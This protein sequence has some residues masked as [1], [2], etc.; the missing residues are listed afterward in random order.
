[1]THPVRRRTP[2]SLAAALVLAAAPG[3]ACAVEPL[4]TFSVSVGSYIT[5]FD[6]RLRADGEALGGTS[7]DLS[8]DLGV[9]S[10]VALGFARVTW[11]PFERHEIGLSYFGN[12][13]DAERK[14]E[15]EIVFEDSVYLASATVRGRYDLDS[16][17]GYYTWWGF[18]S[19]NWALGPR[20]GVT[21]YRLALGLE[22]KADV[23]GDP[24]VDGTLE[25]SVNADLPAPTLGAAWRWTPAENWRIVADAGWFSTEINDIDGNVTY[26]RGGVEWYPWPRVGVMLDYTFSDIDARTARDAF[27]GHLELRN[28]GLRMG[29]VY[30]F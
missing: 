9:D 19:E 26:A 22:L 30:R 14:L 11:R 25:D 17:E 20:L 24:V 12:S 21:W 13:M 28:S 18:L 5:R 16:L 2:S 27:T 4:D 29:L 7:I 6:T 8:R 3:A 15:R 23:N 10:D 1:M